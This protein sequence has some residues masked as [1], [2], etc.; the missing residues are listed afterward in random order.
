MAPGAPGQR[1]PHPAAGSSHRPVREP[2]GYKYRVLYLEPEQLV[3]RSGR[4]LW[5]GARRPPIVVRHPELAQALRSVHSTL[6]FPAAAL[7]Q[8]EASAIIVCFVDD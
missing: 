4:E 2:G 8:G 1:L 6:R 3:E 7:K 5:H